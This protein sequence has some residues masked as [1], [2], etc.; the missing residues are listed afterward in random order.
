MKSLV[1]L[2]VPAC[3]SARPKEPTQR[4]WGSRSA[5]F[6]AGFSG[7]GGSTVIYSHLASYVLVISKKHLCPTDVWAVLQPLQ[8][9]STEEKKSWANDQFQWDENHIKQIITVKLL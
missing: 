1:N 8:P 7:G 5:S 3:E 6:R 2:I 9:P 4:H